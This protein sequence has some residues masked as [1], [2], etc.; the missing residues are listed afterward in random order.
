MRLEL[1]EKKAYNRSLLIS[2]SVMIFFFFSLDQAWI[3]ICR[4]DH[5]VSVEAEVLFSFGFFFFFFSFWFLWTWVPS[6][7]SI[8]TDS[9]CYFPNMFQCL[10]FLST[11]KIVCKMPKIP[12]S[13]SHYNKGSKYLKILL[14][15]FILLQIKSLMV[16]KRS[17]V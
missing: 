11:N 3:Q 9:R 16:N 7:N 10:V 14:Q 2:N 1:N 8:H 13:V 12:H 5:V 4:F 17:R 15:F 6:L